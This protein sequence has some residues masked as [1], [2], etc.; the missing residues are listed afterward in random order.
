[1]AKRAILTTHDYLRAAALPEATAT[2]TVISHGSIIDKTKEILEEK[3]FK[4]ERELYR[5]NEGAQIAQGVY[6]M[7]HPNIMDAEMGIMFCWANSYDKSMKFRC[8]IGGYVHQSLASIIGG[9]MDNFKRVHTGNADEVVVETIQEQID[10]AEEYFKELIAD[11]E[12]MKNTEIST[13]MRAAVAGRLYFNHDLLNGEQMGMI[14]TEFEKPSFVYSGVQNSVWALY[15]NIILALQ[16]SHPRTWMSQQSMIHYFL[17]EY[18]KIQTGVI[19]SSGLNKSPDEKPKEVTI[20]DPAQVDL[21]DMIKEVE[22]EKEVEVGETFAKEADVVITV[23]NPE[24]TP[25]EATEEEVNHELHGVDNNNVE[26]TVENKTAIEAVLE[27][28]EEV[29]TATAE[30][31]EESWPCLKCGNMQ[32]STAVFNDGQLCTSCFDDLPF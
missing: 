2:Y 16:K 5:C 7:S 4:I 26:M 24:I 19:E 9:N 21:E 28:E 29:L 12:T 3:G 22:S 6:H 27:E 31:D 11:K 8:S 23:E 32:A 10:K 13:E 15:N 1:M 20:Q 18:M 17:C 14:K 30:V 25:V